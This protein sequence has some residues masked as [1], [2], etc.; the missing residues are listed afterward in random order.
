MGNPNKILSEK[1]EKAFMPESD[2]EIYADFY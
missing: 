2:F 1:F